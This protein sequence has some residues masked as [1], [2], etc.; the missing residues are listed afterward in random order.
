MSPPR[1]AGDSPS[2]ADVARAAGVSPQTVSRVA[3][4]E[5]TVSP[6]TRERVLRA[7][8][9]LNYRPNAAARAMKRGSYKTIGIVY[10]SL[11]SVGT[12]M[13]VEVISRKAAQSGYATL[14]LPLEVPTQ[15]NADG[16][17]S[18]LEEMAADAVIAIMPNVFAGPTKAP[19]FNAAPTLV[20]A[21]SAAPGVASIDFDHRGGSKQAV[22]HLLELGHITVD[23]IA[24]TRDAPDSVL[25]REGWE[26]ALKAA[27]RH[28]PEPVYGDWTPGSGYRAAKE[29]LSRRRLPTA[30]YVANDKMALGAYR[31]IREQ[32]LR[33]PE[34]VSVIGFDNVDEAAV[35]DPPLTTVEQDFDAFGNEALAMT[36]DM[37]EGAA[38]DH[39][40]IPTRLAVRESTAAPRET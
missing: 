12:Q 25:R 26:D 6:K 15:Q 23:H 20:V 36:L 31:A 39:R 38:P 7:I 40:I 4:G 37:I 30:I 22:D 32:G 17:I 8:R 14:L 1:K 16:A 18:R 27:N 9:D 5:P 35:Y 13:P 3:N 21:S 19:T 2:M 28:V 11:R 24:G 34:D 33:I 29:L 10:H